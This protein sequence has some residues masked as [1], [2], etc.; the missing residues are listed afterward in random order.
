M[1]WRI[2][3]KYIYCMRTRFHLIGNALNADVWYSS[4]WHCKM[5]QG[6]KISYHLLESSVTKNEPIT[7]YDCQAGETGSCCSSDIYIY[8]YYMFRIDIQTWIPFRGVSDRR[9]ARE[10]TLIGMHF[11]NFINKI[12]KFVDWSIRM[13]HFD[14][15]FLRHL[16][17]SNHKS[18]NITCFSLCFFFLQFQSFWLHYEKFLR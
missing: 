1:I 15:I 10:K 12:Y 17:T 8:K 2:K 7:A 16:S 14:A 6:F 5:T 11:V 18:C 4:A 13:I 3:V 9:N